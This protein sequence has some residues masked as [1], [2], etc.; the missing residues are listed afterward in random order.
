MPVYADDAHEATVDL[1]AEQAA[2]DAI[3]EIPLFPDLPVALKDALPYGPHVDMLQHFVYWFHPRKPKMQK[4][5]WLYKTYAEWR[6]EC[7]LRRKQV[8]KGRKVLRELGLV[9]EKKGPHGRIHYRVEWAALASK[10]SLPPTGEQT[11]ED[12][13][14]FFD[15]DDEISLSPIGEQGQFVPQGEQGSLS[16]VGGHANTGDY[17][18]DYLT[19]K[20]T[21]QV[22]A[23]PAKAEPALLLMDKGFK[24]KEHSEE[25]P[26]TEKR[27]FQEALT[28]RKRTAAIAV[29]E[30]A[31]KPQAPPKPED[32]TFLDEVRKILDPKTDQWWGA[33]FVESKRQQYTPELV[34]KLLADD[35]GLSYQERSAELEPVVRYVLWEVLQHAEEVA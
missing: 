2:R 7:G 27:H 31:P 16:P 23:E 25:Q 10:L 22:G 21:L 29:V 32:D 19:E 1:A 15:L 33:K 4:R 14:D 18:G 11:D 17:T 30:E 28:H 20:S 5:W 6:D 26:D 34:T 24:E 35:E 8:D 3:M 12:D 9:A 13:N